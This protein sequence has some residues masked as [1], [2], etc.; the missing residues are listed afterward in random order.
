RERF[1][2][3][4]REHAAYLPGELLL[5]LQR[6]LRR[7]VEQ[8]VVGNAAPQEERQARGELVFSKCVGGA[9]RRI[10]RVDFDAVQELRADEQ[11]AERQLDAVL[12]RT[13][14]VAFVVE[15]EQFFQLG[16]SG[17]P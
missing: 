10:G 11:P 8:R 4:I 16:I 15:L 6:A 12:E 14:D 7:G 3:W 13:V 5:V 9:C 17:G 2:P 1:G